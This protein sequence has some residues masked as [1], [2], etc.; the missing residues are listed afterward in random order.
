MTN[1]KKLTSDSGSNGQI[2]LPFGVHMGEVSLDVPQTLDDEQIITLGDQLRRVNNAA[3]W[4]L[5][6]YLVLV[7][8]LFKDEKHPRASAKKVYDRV[9]M[10]FPQHERGTLRELAYV[11][12]SVPADIRSPRLSFA[13]HR[14]L[15]PLATE[16]EGKK[17]QAHY[18]KKAVELE[19]TVEDLRLTIA[20]TRKGVMHQLAAKPT[21]RLKN[22][23]PADAGDE[24]DAAG[25]PGDGLPIAR[26][27]SEP[28]TMSGSHAQLASEAHRALVRIRDWY[29]IE[30]KKSRGGSEWSSD[31]REALIRDL[32]PVLDEMHKIAEIAED[33]A[34]V[35]EHDQE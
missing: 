14:H 34:K 7:L 13:H 9:C 27:P 30:K 10:L 20:D 23:E 17:L 25:D 12:R 11:A 33:L 16:T 6:D 18:L 26:P 5:A 15:A 32:E 24:A 1:R 19:M 2:T 4:W 8:D 28:E 35:G 22:A 3:P 21:K 31:R 29:A